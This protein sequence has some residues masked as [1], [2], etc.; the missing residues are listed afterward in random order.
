LVRLDGR[1]PA[2]GDII[3]LELNPRTGREQAGYRPAIV[4][5]PVAYN[6]ISQIVLVCPIT[7]RK[8]GWPFEVELPNQMQTHG[9][10]LVD[11]IRAVDCLARRAS[12]VEEAPPELMD[13]I[14]ARLE[15][16]SA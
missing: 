7:S 15:T 3:Y 1:V 16:L 2:R 14:L 6:Q 12:F 13:E 11:Q 4:I 8:K 5:S 10:V 9:V